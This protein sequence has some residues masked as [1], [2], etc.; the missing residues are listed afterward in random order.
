MRSA[1][2]HH[3]LCQGDRMETSSGPLM[4]TDAEALM[5]A[6]NDLARDTWAD[7]QREFD[8]EERPIDRYVTHQVGVRHRQLLLETLGMD[9]K[10]DFPTVETLGNVGSVSLPLCF[11]MA[12]EANFIQPGHRVAMFGIGSGLHCLMLAVDW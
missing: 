9:P 5:L 1:T 4:H 11:S 8:F 10:R 7:F 6:G 12:E 2:Q 3:E